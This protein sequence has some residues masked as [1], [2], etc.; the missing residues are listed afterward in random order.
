MNKYVYDIE[1]FKNFFTSTFVSV[2]DET[3]SH[4][5]SIGLGKNDLSSLKEFLEQE[6]VLIGYNNESYDNPILRFIYNFN[7]DKNIN[8]EIFNLS[9]KLIND[10]YR[11]DKQILSLR[12]PKDSLDSWKSIDLMKILAFDKLGISLKQTAINLKW[13][14][15]QDIPLSPDIEVQRSDVETICSYNI[16]DVLITKK[17]YEEITPLRT[18]REEL[19]KIYNIDFSSASDSKIANL[20]LE[21]T[22]KEQ[23]KADMSSIKKMRTYREKVLLRECIA[24]FVEFKTPQLK[25]L[26]DRISS[27]VV[28]SYTNFKYSE[29][30]SYGGCTFD[31]GIGGL[32]SEDAPGKFISDDEYLIQDMDVASYYPNLIINN[33][34]YP[35]HLGEGFIEVLKKITEERLSAKKSGDKVK[36]DGLKITINSIFGKLGSDTFW[37]LDPKQLLSTTVSGQLG[38]LM[39]IESLTLAGIQVISANTDGVV[40]KIKRDKLD[41]YYEIARD[42]ENK[43]KLQLEFT[44]Y[45][46]YVRRDVNS[47]ITQKESG[48]IKEKGVFL[49]GVDLKKAYRMPIVAKALRNYFI[50]S[51]P[52]KETIELSKDIMDFCISQKTDSSFQLELHTINGIQKL[53]KTNRYYISKNGGSLIKRRIGTDSKIGMNVGYLATILN[54]YDSS[55]PFEEYN[56]NFSFYISEVMKIIDEIEPKQDFLFDVSL[57]TGEGIKKMKMPEQ[58]EKEVPDVFDARELNR[59]DKKQ[60]SQKLTEIVLEHK[61]VSGISSRYVYIIS[62]NKS[63]M[64]ADVYC[65]KKGIRD[66][67]SVNKVEYS[68]NKNKID[69][70]QLVYC[71]KFEKIKEGFAI[72]E[73]TVDEKFK[74]EAEAL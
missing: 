11:D 37:L 64:T 73:Y 49:T 38:L 18:L 68:K 16:N 30:I 21:K 34:F 27:T 63:T 19:G 15:I 42:W 66:L 4:V 9:Y 7:E 47:Y 41:K 25:D 33:K 48:D 59:L 51:I 58:R 53:Q 56:V 20:I 71:K 61:S 13:K 14:K 74:I 55:V 62:F 60:F 36:A 2:D 39:L 40:C 23:L 17:L 31:L 32:H 10:S 29:K 46:L 8:K 3:E 22:Y 44:P 69:K 57:F 26:F 65:L 45:K 54:D 67:I 1:V 52:V 35:R 70:N 43:T 6:I 24:S 50:N 28:Y 12:Y 72:K 5:F